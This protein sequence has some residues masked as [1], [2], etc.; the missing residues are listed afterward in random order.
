MA[1]AEPVFRTDHRIPAAWRPHRFIVHIMKC[2]S[3]RM[4]HLG[5][6]RDPVDDSAPE[7]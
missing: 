2:P 1:I 7:I 5:T 4:R 6:R 3:C